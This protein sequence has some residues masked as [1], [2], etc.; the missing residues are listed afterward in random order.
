MIS[1]AEFDEEYL[2][3]LNLAAMQIDLGV[4]F[5]QIEELDQIAVLEDECGVGVQFCQ[6]R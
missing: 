6:R 1:W 5:G 3:P 4:I 2:E